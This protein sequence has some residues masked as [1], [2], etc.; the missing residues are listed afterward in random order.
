[1]QE[2]GILTL[3]NFYQ[4]CQHNNRGMI[5]VKGK[6]T[7]VLEGENVL[8]TTS[9]L[10]QP[11]VTFPNGENAD[12]T[13]RESE[14]GGSLTLKMPEGVGEQR[15]Y[16]YG[17]FADHFV[18]ESGT[19]HSEMVLCF[20]STFE[21]KGGN[22]TIDKNTGIYA[23]IQTLLGDVNLNGGKLT[24]RNAVCGV[25][26][27]SQ[28]AYTITVDGAE[29]DIQATVV[30]LSGK[31][32]LFKSGK[33][34]VI[35]GT[36][37]TNVAADASGYQGPGFLVGS[38]DEKGLAPRR[39]DVSQYKTYKRIDLPHEHVGEGNWL[40]D[41]EEHWKLCKCT[42][43]AETAAHQFGEWVTVE[44]ATQT[45]E[46]VREHKCDICGKVVQEAIPFLPNTGDSAHPGVYALLLVLCGAALIL[47]RRKAVR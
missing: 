6:I 22:V 11:L 42:E 25:A 40:S 23:G 38:V 5:S 39:Y 3:R 37:A 28:E 30:G 1:M 8:E 41:D 45:K 34:V 32:I 17:F 47:L 10:Y 2:G 26:A 13:I 7:L 29:L 21:M 36:R 46:G 44:A 33:A 16:P 4:K 24:V 35:G 27:K 18:V 15:Y 19:I 31:A 43:K 14:A 12:W 9:N 20:A